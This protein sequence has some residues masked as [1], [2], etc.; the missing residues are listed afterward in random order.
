[1][2]NERGKAMAFFDD[3]SK[4]ISQAS[5]GVAQSTKNFANIT[6]LNNMVSEEEKKIETLY[7]QLGRAYYDNFATSADPELAGYIN[8]INTALA[9]I[10]SYKNQI[11]EIKGVTSCPQCGAEISYASAFCN[12][13]GTRLPERAPVQAVPENTVQCANCGAFIPEGYKFCTLCGSSMTAP[14]PAEPVAEAAEEEP[15]ASESKVCPNC[16]KEL[17]ADAIFCTICGQKV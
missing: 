14:A 4:K 10:E 15:V 1:M 2:L 12:N 3:I 17:T 5:Q 13:C 9:N 7:Y 11:K 8:A 16:G 6:K